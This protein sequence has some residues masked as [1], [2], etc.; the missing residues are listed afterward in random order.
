[1]HMWGHMMPKRG[2]SE[3]PTRIYGR[4]LALLASKDDHMFVLVSSLYAGMDWRQ[5][6]SILVTPNEA[7]DDRGSISVFFK[8]I[9][10][11]FIFLINLNKNDFSTFFNLFY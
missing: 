5:F 4:A 9:Q 1:M 11:H 10:F 3:Y 2:L 7:I 6:P 8:L